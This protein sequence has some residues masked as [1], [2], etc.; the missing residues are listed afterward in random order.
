MKALKRER[1]PL[2]ERLEELKEQDGQL[3]RKIY[4]HYSGTNRLS[5]SEI[6]E[7]ERAYVF[8]QSVL[9]FFDGVEL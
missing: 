2:V 5:S 8:T 3:G 1:R 9:Q 7:I 6:D 4:L